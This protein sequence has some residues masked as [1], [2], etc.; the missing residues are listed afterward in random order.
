M[1]SSCGC[2]RQNG[3][4]DCGSGNRPIVTTLVVKYF[5]AGESS[6]VALHYIEFG[7]EEKIEMLMTMREVELKEGFG[8]SSS[9]V[10]W[11]NHIAGSRSTGVDRCIDRVRP[12]NAGQRT[13]SSKFPY[14]KNH[15]SSLD[16]MGL[17]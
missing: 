5:D 14:I 15:R 11:M 3:N 9:L 10:P 17:G 2:V 13:R 16:N 4:V 12:W 6:S 7:K 8:I 1:S